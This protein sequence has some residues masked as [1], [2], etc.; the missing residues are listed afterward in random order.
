MGHAFRFYI[1]FSQM[2]PPL[3]NLSNGMKKVCPFLC[4]SYFKVFWPIATLHLCL[5]SNFNC[6]S[7]LGP[8]SLGQLLAV[9]MLYWYKVLQSLVHGVTEF[10]TRR[11]KVLYKVWQSLVQ[12]V[13]RSGRAGVQI[14][15]GHSGSHTQFL[16][17]GRTEDEMGISYR[18]RSTLKVV[19]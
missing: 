9:Y 1:S 4:W 13:T 5:I 2:N 8:A 10:C 15:P 16:G 6:Y 14:R 17:D 7:H 19:N 11:E 18:I 3:S 12:G